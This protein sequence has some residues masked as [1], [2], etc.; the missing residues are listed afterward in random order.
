[1][2]RIV[3]KKES[4]VMNSRDDYRMGY[5]WQSDDAGECSLKSCYS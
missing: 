3:K 1:M 2:G 4:S 5:L